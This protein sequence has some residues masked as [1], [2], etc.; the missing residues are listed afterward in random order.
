MSPRVTVLVVNYMAGSYLAECLRHLTLQTMRDF[1]A[2]VVD[3]GSADGSL[4]LAR[5]AVAGDT[6]FTFLAAERNLGFAAGNNRAADAARAPLLA[7]LNPDAF[8]AADWL[9][10]LLD[11]ADRHPGVAMFGS[12][13]LKADDPAVLD[14]AG[15]QYFFIGLPWRGG[16]GWPAASLGSEGEVFGPCAAAALYRRAAFSAVGGFDESFFCYVE[17][18]DLAFRLRARGHRCVQVP[19]AVVRHVGGASAQA[20]SGFARYHGIRN[21]IWCFVK[22]M[23]SPLFWPILPMHL[24]VMTLVAA[25]AHFQGFPQG[26]SG[27]IDALRCLPWAARKRER[28]ERVVSWPRLASAMVWRPG[29][30][31]S[32]APLTLKR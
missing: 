15:D 9:E 11:A 21:M 25:R 14:G 24:A 1:E 23:P 18:V 16:F 27:L 31:C 4:D 10:I 30:Y 13:Q 2:I 3:N 29:P 5:A 17:D 26:W 32:R 6:R 20:I 8:P 12:T 22:N 19:R 28:A 7:T